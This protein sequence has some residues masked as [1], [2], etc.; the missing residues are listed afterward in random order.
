MRKECSDPC[1][2]NRLGSN[3][4]SVD[5]TSVRQDAPHIRISPSMSLTAWRLSC[6]CT[7]ISAYSE[8][9]VQNL[10]RLPTCHA[11]V[12]GAKATTRS[13]GNGASGLGN[14]GQ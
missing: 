9:V 8:Y 13:G 3:I 10:V 14:Q 2:G 5:T 4:W 1:I 11:T 6:R 7:H 12:G